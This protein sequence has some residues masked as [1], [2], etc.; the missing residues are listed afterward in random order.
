MYFLQ[1][2][3]TNFSKCFFFLLMTEW[4]Q[5]SCFQDSSISISKVIS[6]L[7][8]SGSSSDLLFSQCLFKKFSDCSNDINYNWQHNHFHIHIIFC[9]SRARS[10]N[11]FIFFVFFYFYSIVVWCDNI[12]FFLLLII[13]L[14]FLLSSTLR[15][16]PSI[17]LG[18]QPWR[19]SLCWDFY[20]AVWFRVVFSFTWD[21][22]FFFFLSSP[23]VWWYPFLIFPSVCKFPFLQAF[24]F[25]LI[26]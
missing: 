1:V 25:F 12:D 13:D 17:L 10:K 15:I 2:L 24:W 3:L 19:L 6:K 9:R 16:V 11:L 4:R 7:L 22:L 21:I 26:W 18:G 5:I 8:W 14:V 20:Y 23:I